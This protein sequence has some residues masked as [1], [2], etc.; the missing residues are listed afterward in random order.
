MRI[1]LLLAIILQI[2]V[3][4]NLE[5]LEVNQPVTITDSEIMPTPTSTVVNDRAINI[6]LILENSHQCH[7]TAKLEDILFHRYDIGSFLTLTKED[8]IP[9]EPGLSRVTYANMDG[10]IVVKEETLPSRYSHWD[11]SYFGVIEVVRIEK[12]VIMG[13]IGYIIYFSNSSQLQIFA[14]SSLGNF[15]IGRQYYQLDG[16][17]L[18]DV[19]TKERIFY[20]IPQYDIPY[21]VKIRATSL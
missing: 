7:I 11:S 10:E 13:R 2:T 21:L 5:S 8:F 12:Y 9:N 16:L 4:T 20:A 3:L 15:A 18:M 6:K 1:T 19:T 17:T 14:G